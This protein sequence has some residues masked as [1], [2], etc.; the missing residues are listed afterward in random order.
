MDFSTNPGQDHQRAFS[1]TEATHQNIDRNNRWIVLA[2][3]IHWEKLIAHYTSNFEF[4]IVH[5]KVNPRTM[6]AAYIIKYKLKISSRATVQLINENQYLQHFAEA[7][8]EFGSPPLTP[9]LMRNVRDIFGKSE[10]SRFKHIILNESFSNFWG[11]LGFRLKQKFTESN[12]KPVVS[13]VKIKTQKL[14]EELHDSLGI[15]YDSKAESS[16]RTARKKGRDKSK[17]IKKKAK[18]ILDTVLWIFII[19]LILGS[20]ALIVKESEWSYN[21]KKSEKKK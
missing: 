18:K 20:L 16:G 7:G 3:E 6:V 8:R 14:N 10:W 2:S 17:K 12:K 21:K 1:E 9:E 15:E 13:N 11:K 4:E 19:I 5:P